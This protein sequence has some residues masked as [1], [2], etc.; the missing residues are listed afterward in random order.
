M[1]E[2][3]PVHD[4][5]AEFSDRVRAAP[6]P[7]S[8]V[9]LADLVAADASENLGDH[10]L[11][12]TVRRYRGLVEPGV[13]PQSAH[14]VTSR[15]LAASQGMWTPVAEILSAR[16]P[17][18]RAVF[19]DAC[20][21]C[22]LLG[23]MQPD[24]DHPRSV[25]A[26]LEDGEGRYLIERF[27]AQGSGGSVAIAT[28]RGSPGFRS[29]VA[30]KFIRAEPGDGAPER[31][32][33]VAGGVCGPSA[34][35]VVEVGR[36]QGGGYLV[37]DLVGGL[38]LTAVAATER[39]IDPERAAAEVSD[40]AWCVADLHSAG[41]VHGDISPTNV[42]LDDAGRLRLVD[43][44][45]AGPRSPD[46]EWND[47][48]MLA[49]LLVWMLLGYVPG[50]G[51]RPPVIAITVRQSVLVAAM[52]ALREPTVAA[53]FSERVDAAVHRARLF[54]GLAVA[55]GVFAALLW[56]SGAAG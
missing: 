3:R 31:E 36:W 52:R 46:A 6:G 17:R 51:F 40:L 14:E 38:A 37:M 23:P 45:R 56:A 15:V 1:A 35:R 27:V 21:A 43:F 50:P 20:L 33:V 13:T 54:R 47:V 12:P 41:F 25:G 2:P 48:R 49:A 30:V 26:A 5:P 28:D 34:V 22:E 44:G 18:W 32:A 9:A 55:L 53:D 42:M 7:L 16:Y 11:V 39:M 8:D 24:E 10:L 19:T 29:Q 4:R